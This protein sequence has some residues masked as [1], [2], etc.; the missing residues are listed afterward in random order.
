MF[1]VLVTEQYTFKLFYI[2]LTTQRIA[3]L[4]VYKQNSYD[5]YSNIDVSIKKNTSNIEYQKIF[6]SDTAVIRMTFFKAKPYSTTDKYNLDE[7]VQDDW[8]NTNP[9][10][11]ITP[12]SIWMWNRGL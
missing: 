2:W 5:V 6:G 8:K 9:T 11:L 4:S 7:S 10:F 3:F 1:T 12:Y